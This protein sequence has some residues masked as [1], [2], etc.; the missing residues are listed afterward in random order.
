[1]PL[2]V[3]MDASIGYRKSNLMLSDYHEKIQDRISLKPNNSRLSGLL[4]IPYT[5]GI[6]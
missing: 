4:T 6:N 2:Q 1:M 3:I 5:P